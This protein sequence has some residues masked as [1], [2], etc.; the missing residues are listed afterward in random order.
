MPRR[1]APASKTPTKRA[2]G[3]GSVF[4]NADGTWTARLPRDGDGKR[5]TK[6]H[7]SEAEALAWLRTQL[8]PIQDGPA[9]PSDE[10]LGDYLARWLERREPGLAPQSIPEYRRAVK[11]CAPI[12]RT[13]LGELNHTH[14]QDVLAGLQR[15]GLATGTVK[16]TRSILA[17]ALEDA[18]P[19][20]L[21]ANPLKRTNPGR[22]VRTQVECWSR[23]QAERVILASTGHL[24]EPL[25]RIGI[26]AGLR[27][28]ELLA[29]QWGDLAPDGWL[30]VRRSQH[31]HGKGVGPTKSRRERRI[32]LSLGL[33]AWLLARPRQSIWI[34]ARP[35]GQAYGRDYFTNCLDQFAAAAK[36]P[37]LHPHAACR[38]TAANI[39]LRA[40]VPI[41][42]VSQILGHH[43]AGFT[44][45]IYGGLCPEDDDLSTAAMD[46][47]AP[48]AVP[49]G[50]ENGVS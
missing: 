44:L 9:S 24:F 48:E 43:S 11:E 45:A 1:K 5:R 27:T 50:T 22:E 2:Y 12:A 21:R 15:R 42:K 39:M 6:R 28:G 13:P 10:L 41:T 30:T 35:D 37:R 49:E 33:T 20:P 3:G 19:E 38:H 29:L 25:V 31:T 8:A 46:S 23:D 4:L 47:L 17:A 40:H 36:V 14:F 32:R 26:K 7:R 16:V 34:V 18:V